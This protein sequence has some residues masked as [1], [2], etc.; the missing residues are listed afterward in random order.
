MFIAVTA[1]VMLT[2]PLAAVLGTIVL[3][4][5]LPFVL[6]AIGGVWWALSRSY[7]EGELIERL[8][9]QSDMLEVTRR[10]PDGTE[11]HWRANPYWV[12]VSLY[13]TGGAVPHYLTLKAEGREVELGAFLTETE[14][15]DL[16][17]DLRVRLAAL[18]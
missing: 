14:R 8:I 9:L 1:F 11:L 6:L 7:R 12:S 5:L 2:L 18:H 16:A 17:A 10:A 15:K 4:G 13:P 3:W